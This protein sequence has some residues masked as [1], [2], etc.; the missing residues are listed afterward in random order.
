MDF[1]A[2]VAD[3]M[4]FGSVN[5]YLGAHQ[6]PIHPDGHDLIVLWFLSRKR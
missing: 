6:E 3:Y 2:I 1:L 4:L 5:D